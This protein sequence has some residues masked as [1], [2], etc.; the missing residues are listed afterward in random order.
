MS[1]FLGTLFKPSSA[2]QA[3]RPR[4]HVLSGITDGLGPHRLSSE[5]RLGFSV[6]CGPTDN[7]LPELWGKESF[8]GT[9]QDSTSSVSFTTKPLIGNTG[10]LDITLPLANTVFQNGRRSTLYASRWDISSEGSMALRMRHPKT[11]QLIIDNGESKDYTSSMIPLLPLTPPRKIVASLGNIVRQVE[12]GGS[13]NPASKELEIIIPKIFE[14]RARC[15]PAYSP[16]PIGVW[17]WVI[18]PH[19]ME[20][21]KFDNLQLFNAGCSQTETDIVLSS[22]NLFSELL[23]SGCR[24]HKIRKKG[25]SYCSPGGANHSV[26]SGGGGWGVKQGLLSLDPETNFSLPGQDDDMEMFI[27]S[28]EERNGAEPAS[29]LATP[30]SYLLFCVEPRMT[31]VETLSNQLSAPAKTTLAFGVVASSDYAPSSSSRPD[32]IEIIDGHFGISS[33]TGLFLRATPEFHVMDSDR[34][35]RGASRGS[36]TTKVD[37]PGAYFYT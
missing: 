37:V 26:V 16:T 2:V 7:I 4:L 30:G 1:A 5:P 8:A 20:A 3:N 17:C 34:V 25:F 6:L 33:A 24:L 18:P 29:G 14:E 9:S 22:M 32:P 12:V 19:L 23:S 36:F 15:D 13:P 10:A 28:F 27:R 31:D 21:N 35:G 11:T